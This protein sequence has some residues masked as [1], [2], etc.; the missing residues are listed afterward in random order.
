M[1][2]GDSTARVLEA[3]GRARGEKENDSRPRGRRP[4]PSAV[5]WLPG[6][7]SEN[8]CI[9]NQ[10]MRR[11]A[12]RMTLAGPPWLVD[13][14]N[15]RRPT[16]GH[17]PKALV[18]PERSFRFPLSCEIQRDPPALLASPPATAHSADAYCWAL[19]AENRTWDG[20]TCPRFSGMTAMSRCL[21][22]V[23]TPCVD[24]QARLPPCERRHWRRSLAAYEA[25]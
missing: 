9:P 5:C 18:V 22:V 19:L 15:H 21:R 3:A 6:L 24:R 4:T 25:G 11:P 17:S 1:T 20:S 13:V 10:G 16:K 7:G 8:G 14:G 12:R 23:L 2:T